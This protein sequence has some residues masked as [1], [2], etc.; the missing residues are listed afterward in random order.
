MSKMFEPWLLQLFLVFLF[1]FSSFSLFFPFN[2]H[3]SSKDMFRSAQSKTHISEH[4]RHIAYVEI[5]NNVET[6][7]RDPGK[8]SKHCPH[9]M[10]ALIDDVVA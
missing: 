7:R 4:L 3:S 6:Q 2:L 9:R 8:T 5:D 10:I 1:S